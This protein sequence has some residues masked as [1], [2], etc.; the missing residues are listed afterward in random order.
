MYERSVSCMKEKK[1][2]ELR[3]RLMMCVSTL[4]RLNGR[5]PG[6]LELYTALGNEFEEVLKEYLEK[7]GAEDLDNCVTQ[8]PTKCMTA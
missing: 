4:Y 2:D 6:A 3:Q 1:N 7:D 5:K 8:G